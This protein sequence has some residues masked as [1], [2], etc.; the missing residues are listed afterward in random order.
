MIFANFVLLHAFLFGRSAGHGH[1]LKPTP[2]H[3]NYPQPEFDSDF[4]ENLKGE[5]SPCG[6]F[7]DVDFNNGTAADFNGL[8]GQVVPGEV[9]TLTIEMAKD[10]YGGFHTAKFQCRDEGS[11]NAEWTVLRLA[12]DQ[13]EGNAQYLNCDAFIPGSATPET[14]MLNYEIP[15]DFGKNGCAAGVIQ[16]TF[17]PA[18]KCIPL[19][20]YHSM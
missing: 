8:T 10:T 12:A 18:R 4:A 20:F 13:M 14:Y 9:F 16:W 19:D 6:K 1:I 3:L 17:S 2:R 7:W 5:D 15:A 11:D